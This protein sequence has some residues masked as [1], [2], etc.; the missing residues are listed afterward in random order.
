VKVLRAAI[1]LVRP[2]SSLLLFAMLFVPLV[3][4][5]HDVLA[6]FRRSIPMFLIG[7]CTFIA[8]DLDDI[9]TDKVNH[10]ERA[11]PSQNITP[12]LAAALYFICLAAAL[13]T[14]LFFVPDNVAFF[15]YLTI[16]LTISYRYVVAFVPLVKAP[17]SAATIAIPAIILLHY[18]A[19]EPNAYLVVLA[20][21]AFALGREL[22]MDVVDR[23]GDARSVLHRVDADSVATHAFALQGASLFLILV[24]RARLDL[25]AVMDLA[26][27]VVLFAIALVCWFGFR[28]RDRAVEVMKVQ[29][30][31]GLYFLI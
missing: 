16:T 27:I 11:L 18:K 21:F 22:C 23:A 1:E 19:S 31:L 12:I 10:P 8:N 17:Y 9:E 14:T 30:L 4:G 7:M 20:V 25:W 15:Y 24:S 6:S 13:L 28:Q 26:T 29:L 5:S 2:G 3:S